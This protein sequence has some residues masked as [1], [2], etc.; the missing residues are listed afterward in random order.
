MKRL[1]HTIIS[2]FFT[3]VLLVAQDNNNQP[4]NTN[5]TN[6]KIYHF[7]EKMPEY[8]GG[9]IALRRYLV[10]NLKYPNAQASYQGKVYIRFIIDEDGNVIKPEVTRGVESLLDKEAIRVV[11][12][13]PKW[14]PGEHN[15]KRVKVYYT[16]PINFKL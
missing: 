13:L 6:D 3:S 7:V 10:E 16:V 15:G 5:D 1:I 14:I 12:S 4:V 11:K 2:I 8:P 9:E